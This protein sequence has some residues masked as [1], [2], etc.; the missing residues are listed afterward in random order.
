MFGGAACILTTALITLWH[1]PLWHR[2]EDPG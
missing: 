1:R 2:A